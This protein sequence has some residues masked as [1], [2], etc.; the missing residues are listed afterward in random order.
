MRK[1][2]VKYTTTVYYDGSVEIVD[3]VKGADNNSED[4]QCYSLGTL[5][6]KLRSMNY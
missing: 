3:L 6:E 1:V 2:L 4:I 5:D